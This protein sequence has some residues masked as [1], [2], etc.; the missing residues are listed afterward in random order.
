MA[1]TSSS[2]QQKPCSILWDTVINYK[3]H[4]AP[5]NFNQSVYSYICWQRKNSPALLTW[6]GVILTPD[7]SHHPKSPSNSHKPFSSALGFW[8][9]VSRHPAVNFKP[10]THTR[11]PCCPLGT[12]A[13]LPIRSHNLQGSHVPHHCLPVPPTRAL[14]HTLFPLSIMLPLCYLLA[15]Q[16]IRY[17]CSQ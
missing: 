11:S 14:L 12:L 2:V 8:K 13:P 6:S 9:L 15:V 1:T 7:F 4:H 17:R 5:E 10:L 16:L 3:C